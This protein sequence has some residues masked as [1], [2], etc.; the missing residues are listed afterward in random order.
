MRWKEDVAVDRKDGILLRSEKKEKKIEKKD[1]DIFELMDSGICDDDEIL[2][3]LSEQSGEDAISTGFRLAQFVED[4]GD[5]LAE[6][7]KSKVFGA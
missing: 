1:L 6:G 3:R 5:F 2:S 4:Y 7:E